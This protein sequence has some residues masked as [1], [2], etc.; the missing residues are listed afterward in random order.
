ML[1][2]SVVLRNDFAFVVP[3]STRKP[4]RIDFPLQSAYGV[5]PSRNRPHS[6]VCLN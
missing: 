2:F 4:S 6:S 3:N 5:D 1:M